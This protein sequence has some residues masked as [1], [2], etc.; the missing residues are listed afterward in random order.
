MVIVLTGP[1][2][3]GKTTIGR[4]LSGRL[5]WRFE[6]AD[7]FHPQENV[8][9]MKSGVPLDDNDRLPWLRVLHDMI[10]DSVSN[11]ENMILACSALKRSYRQLLGVDQQS[12]MSIYLKGSPE[13][14]EKRV[15]L[16]T[17]Q[18]MNKDLLTSQ[19]NTLEEP[20]DGLVISIAGT[21]EQVVDEIVDR[22][23][24]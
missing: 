5:G 20:R 11:G 14:L 9:K 1:M 18:Y 15:A 22:I 2:G 17:H 21:P 4:L 12:V 3:C 8:D 13:L 23:L 24:N 19:L 16:R 10:N 6:D 7:D